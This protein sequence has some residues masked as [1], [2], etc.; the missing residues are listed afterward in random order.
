MTVMPDMFDNLAWWEKIS[1]EQNL[2]KK[3]VYGGI[4]RQS[5]S[6]GEVVPW[7]EFGK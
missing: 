6:A 4:E 3:L 7:K 1:G 2:L 5:R